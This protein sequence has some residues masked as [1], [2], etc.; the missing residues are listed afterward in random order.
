MNVAGYEIT[1]ME[2][3]IYIFH[4]ALDDLDWVGQL[5]EN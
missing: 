3:E 4:Y 5:W 2:R 1:G